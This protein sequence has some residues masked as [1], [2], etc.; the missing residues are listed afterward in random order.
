MQKQ[1][2]IYKDREEMESGWRK[3]WDK[4]KGID[5]VRMEGKEAKVGNQ[6]S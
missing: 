1:N 4:G 2:G 6:I 3:G 5:R